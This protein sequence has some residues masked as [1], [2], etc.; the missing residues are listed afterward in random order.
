MKKS[1]SG[2]SDVMDVTMSDE[3]DAMGP[4]KSHEIHSGEGLDEYDDDF[5]ALETGERPLEIFD[6]RYFT[7]FD[8]GKVNGDALVENVEKNPNSPNAW[9]LLAIYQLELDEGAR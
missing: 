7:V 3:T 5:L 1:S 9:L 8:L 2:I 4:A 6:A